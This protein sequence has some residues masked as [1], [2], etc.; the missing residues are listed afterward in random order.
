MS[1]KTSEIKDIADQPL[2][3]FRNSTIYLKPGA[4]QGIILRTPP[5]SEL[6]KEEE[7]VLAQID[8]YALIPIDAYQSLNIS[9]QLWAFY[10]QV[11]SR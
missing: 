1:S 7:L 5:V 4:D 3:Y 6:Q 9:E 2:S 8:G 10:N 11:N